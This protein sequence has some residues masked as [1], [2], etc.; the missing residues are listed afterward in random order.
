MAN[1]PRPVAATT[2][3][4]KE[5]ALL[6]LLESAKASRFDPFAGPGDRPWP[7]ASEVCRLMHAVAP[8]RALP[9]GRRVLLAN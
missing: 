8:R 3:T 9:L 5:A 6:R 1:K 2:P 7:V 4:D